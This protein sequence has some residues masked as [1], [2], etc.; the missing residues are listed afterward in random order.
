MELDINCKCCFEA[1]CFK[2][3]LL[4]VT[5]KALTNPHQIKCISAPRDLLGTQASKT[6]A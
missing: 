4:F 1:L 2:D 6:I 3:L 5:S